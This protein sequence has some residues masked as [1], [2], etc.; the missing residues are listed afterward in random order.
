MTA[1]TIQN[2][3]LSPNFTTTNRTSNNNSKQLKIVYKPNKI[4]SQTKTNKTNTKKKTRHKYP[5]NR[6]SKHTNFLWYPRYEESTLLLPHGL[7]ACN[8]VL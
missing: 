2:N 8:I 7:K 1:L 6:K 3:I 4:Q 5:Y